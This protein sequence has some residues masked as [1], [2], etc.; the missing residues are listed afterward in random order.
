MSGNET[1]DSEAD[2]PSAKQDEHGT[3]PADQPTVSVPSPGHQ[4]PAWRRTGAWPTAGRHFGPYQIMRR[5]GAGGMGEVYEAEHT[6]SGHRVALKVL[7]HSLGS[8]N[9]QKRFLREGR[10]AASVSHPHSVYVYG[11][12]EIEGIAAISMEIVAGG[13]LADRVKKHGPLPVTEAV[14]AILQVI[15]GLAAAEAG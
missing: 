5:L 14:D 2:R 8:A 1:S 7:R 9:D 6:E 15:S 4:E 10:L 11:T 12:E 3:G 13:T